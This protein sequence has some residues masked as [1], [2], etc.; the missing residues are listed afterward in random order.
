MIIRLKAPGQIYLKNTDNEDEAA[1]GKISKIET[2]YIDKDENP[3]SI[4]Y[5]FQIK[6][7]VCKLSSHD[8]NPIVI[9]WDGDG[10]FYSI[11]VFDGGMEC[12][13]SYMRYNRYEQ[14]IYEEKSNR[15][16]LTQIYT[17]SNGN[18]QNDGSGTTALD[19]RTNTFTADW[20]YW[21]EES[22]SLVSIPRVEVKMYNPPVYMDDSL[23]IDDNRAE[24]LYELYKNKCLYQRFVDKFSNVELPYSTGTV[25]EAGKES[26][27]LWKELSP[28]DSR[29]YVPPAEFDNDYWK[30]NIH[31]AGKYKYFDVDVLLFFITGN[32]DNGSS[33][34]P[35]LE[36]CTYR[37]KKIV[38][39]LTVAGGYYGEYDYQFHESIIEKDG[40]IQIIEEIDDRSTTIPVRRKK[41][42]QINENGQL[43]TFTITVECVADKTL[44]PESA[45]K[46]EITGKTIDAESE[47]GTDKDETIKTI[48]Y[49]RICYG[50]G[51]NDL[52]PRGC[53]K[54]V[55]GNV[56]HPVF[57]T[58]KYG[59][60]HRRQSACGEYKAF[61]HL[62]ADTFDTR[63]FALHAGTYGMDGICGFRADAGRQSAAANLRDTVRHGRLHLIPKFGTDETG[64]SG[65]QSRQSA[66]RCAETGG[67]GGGT[68]LRGV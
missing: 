26:V 32:C 14:Y 17:D 61:R 34:S 6:S 44:H 50:R 25:E 8:F 12:H 10:D 59:C 45:D 65:N 67:E 2:A 15:F 5:N 9:E 49:E 42:Y 37:N 66:N 1:T 22:D 51:Y 39:R 24:K 4:Y 16:R 52:H 38:S 41:T 27:F 46:T 21:D 18:A 55:A 29:F 23:W 40:I 30:I 3:D 20:N 60:H 31:A 19:L 58:G 68:V 53:P 11:R 28:Q 57:D 47:G 35:L 48:E 43:C 13:A 7:I 62:L 36:L 54:S 56:Q 64:Q 33:L 63:L